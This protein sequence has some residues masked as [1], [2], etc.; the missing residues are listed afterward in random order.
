M[1]SHT[2]SPPNLR[3]WLRASG[4]RHALLNLV[5][6]A[7]QAIGEQPGTIRISVEGAGKELL[8]RV[9]DDGPGFPEEIL[10]SGVRAFATY[11]E[12]GTGLGLTMVRRFALELAGE[13]VLAN[14]TPTG[15]CVTLR[16]PCQQ[17]PPKTAIAA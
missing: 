12:G 15:A 16:L 8:L 10:V 9:T 17:T 5:L 2:V 13:M 3:C 14:I 11:R 6:N 1:L 4:L 7:A